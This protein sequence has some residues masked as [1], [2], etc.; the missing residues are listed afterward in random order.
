MTK[1]SATKKKMS[2]IP[3]SHSATIPAAVL[4]VSDSAAAGKRKDLSGPAV[5]DVLTQ[6]N[7]K[8]VATE[9]V[10]DEQRQIEA[11]L[12]RLAQ[13][14]HFIVTTGGTGIA[15][16]DVTPEATRAVCERLVEGIAERMRSESTKKTPLAAL[17][18]GICG[19]RGN[20]LILN[21][22]GNPT[23]AVESLRSVLEIIPHA[24]DLLAG[25][26]GH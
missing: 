10:A 2:S 21:V 19:V 9:V 5:T 7:F 23:A 12:R 24:L 15:A 18:R 17:G 8:V 1:P 20:T 3:E 4:T 25:K 26:T 13:K 6:A 16:R 14:A 22:P 11:V